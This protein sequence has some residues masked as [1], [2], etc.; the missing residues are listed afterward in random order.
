MKTKSLVKS[1]GLG[2]FA[3]V[4]ATVTTAS[5]DVVYDNSTGDL[6][7]RLNPLTREVGD[8]IILGGGARILTDFTFEYWGENFFGGDEQARVRFYFNDGAASP[9][10]PLKPGTLFWDSDWFNIVE[11]NRATVV[12]TDFVT[13]AA[14][15]LTQTLPNSFTW[16]IRFRGV[17]AIDGE[18]A[19]V[20]LYDPPTVGGNYYEYWE[21]AGP[22]GWQ[23]RG[24]TNGVHVNFGAKVGAVPEPGVIGLGLLG[25]LSLLVFRSRFKRF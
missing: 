6:N 2:V 14:V 20:D 18:S 24:E 17:D 16:T 3:G 12:F 25:G 11:T 13:G 15:P 7:I 21:N 10:G 4:I 22:S 8:E 1:L 19:G 23:Y 5:A 9:A